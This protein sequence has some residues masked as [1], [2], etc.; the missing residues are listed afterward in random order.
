M[1]IKYKRAYFDVLLER[2]QGPRRF[3]Q[4]L[5][6]PRQVGK[7]TLI[8]QVLEA[9]DR[10][11]VFAAADAEARADRL[12][13]AQQWERARLKA[14]RHPDQTILLVLDEIQKISNWSET[15]KKMWDEDSRTGCAIQPVL[16]GSSA[17]LL[18]KGMSESLA[19]RFEL[20]RVPHW[21]YSEM[22][23]AFGI[24]LDQYIYFGGYPGPAELLSDESRWKQYVRDALIEP[25]ITKDVLLM[26]RIDKPALL[27]QLFHLG[28]V[29]SGRVISYTKL[30]GQLQDAGNTTTLAHYL[31][32]LDTA[33]LLCG[34]QKFTANTIRT[35]GS[36]P[37]LQVHN[38]ALMSALNPDPFETVRETPDR[39]G[40]FFESSVGAHLTRMAFEHGLGLFYW[41]HGND[42]VDFVLTR[43]KR[44]L[45]IEVKSGRK[46]DALNGL[47]KF[48]AQFT[49]HRTLVI[50]TG[51]MP[52][53]EFF[54][55]PAHALFQ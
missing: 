12:W 22:R 52:V 11:F 3:I 5:F 24:T 39:W 51:G 23:S 9:T 15:V 20:I 4:I 2:L 19:G 6:G 8:G 47:K 55:T 17:L 38:T 40:H 33:G 29:N 28:A 1:K 43:E 36:S 45:A 18:Q 21:S 16:L 50:G 7:T 26:T 25:A 37:K 48:N 32:L 14:Q 34:L 30:L 10:S 13:V 42:E 41:R 35:R 27:R 49:P 46:R 53:R 54:E 31:E 44:H